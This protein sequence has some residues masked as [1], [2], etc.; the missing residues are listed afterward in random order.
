MTIT[1][2]KAIGYNKIELEHMKEYITE[3]AP[4]DKATFVA[5]AF[6]TYTDK[7]GAEKKAYSH[8][9]AKKWFCLKYC[10]EIVPKK[11][12]T[13]SDNLAEWI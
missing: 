11:K 3:N 1:E 13:K 6:R 8:L 9:K 7:K 4:D 5:N 2:I 10:P 12:A